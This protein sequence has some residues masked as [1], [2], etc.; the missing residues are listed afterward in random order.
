MIEKE[1]MKDIIIKKTISAL[2]KR[3]F[4]T[5]VAESKTEA[6][7]YLVKTIKKDSSIGFGGSRTLEQIGFH[8]EFNEKKYPG[9]LNR[10][11]KNL[12]QEDKN[13]LQ[14]KSLSA[15][16]FISSCN[17]LSMTGDITFVDKWGNRCG[18]MTYGPSVRIIVASYNKIVPDLQSAVERQQN[19]ASVLNNIRFDTK[20][21]CTVTGKCINCE[22]ENRICGVTTIL[23]RSFP[24]YSVHV[25]ILKEEAGF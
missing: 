17:A 15:D 7:D 18:G 2:E 9:L 24:E 23:H 21:P 3:Y 8:D 5:F 10:E 13:R 14:I 6:L 25:V 11:N 22:S 1:T 12:S 4:K 20:N 19:V 16:Y